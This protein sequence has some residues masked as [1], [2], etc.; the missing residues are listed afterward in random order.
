M[1]YFAEITLEKCPYLLVIDGS[2]AGTEIS[3]RKM[4][5]VSL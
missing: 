5:L 1:V 2:D 4:L 3:E